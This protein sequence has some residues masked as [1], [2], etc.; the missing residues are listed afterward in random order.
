M[1]YYHLFFQSLSLVLLY[2]Y[3]LIP[4]PPSTGNDPDVLNEL[5]V[6]LCSC[7]YV[8]LFFL[9]AFALFI[10]QLYILFFI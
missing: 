1:K 4:Y 7:K 10:W 9:C 3:P 6:D 8:L 5:Y 2:P